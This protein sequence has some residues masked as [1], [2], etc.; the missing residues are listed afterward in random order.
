MG[1]DLV[2]GLRSL[3][4][5]DDVWRFIR[6]FAAEWVSPIRERDDVTP[7]EFDEAEERLGV[8][9][10]EAVR[11]AYQ[12]IGRNPN[13]TSRSGALYEIDE[14]EYD[15]DSRMLTFRCTHQATAFFSMPVRSW[16]DDP[17]VYV[18]FPY[19]PEPYTD[20]FSI[21]LVELVLWETAEAGDRSDGRQLTDY[22]GD[23][24]DGLTPLSTLL[25]AMEWNKPW[26]ISP[27]VILRR[28]GDL[29]TIAARTDE[30][31]TDFRA[32]HPGDW[33]GRWH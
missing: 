12:L 21:N 32:A 28:T 11:Q 27:D 25:P 7:E 22:D 16:D 14:L 6:G 10:P 15:P 20:R 1:F 23:L 17:P 24:L 19:R 29:I 30:A 4:T 5:Y 31:L 8:R 9:L 2:D 33:M 26:H 3:D 13:L 18:D